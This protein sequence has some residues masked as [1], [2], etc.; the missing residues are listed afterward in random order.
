[1]VGYDDYLK[2]N[3]KANYPFEMGFCHWVVIDMIKYT[4]QK[5]FLPNLNS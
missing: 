5:R 1:M 2:E 3:E 4:S